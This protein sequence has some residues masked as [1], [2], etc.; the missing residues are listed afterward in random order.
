MIRVRKQ[1]VDTGVSGWQAVLPERKPTAPL[2]GAI[3]ADLL[4]IGGGFA[5]LAAFRRFNE[6]EPTATVVLLEAGAIGDGPAG[7]N[8]GFM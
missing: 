8:S 2:A 7:R 4:I 6:C 1:P 3:T 5:G